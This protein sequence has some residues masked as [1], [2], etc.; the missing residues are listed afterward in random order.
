MEKTFKTWNLTLIR[1]FCTREYDIQGSKVFVRLLSIINVY[2]QEKQT[3]S[4]LYSKQ[5]FL[6]SG[7]NFEKDHKPFNGYFEVDLGGHAPALTIIW[8]APPSSMCV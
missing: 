3:F 4:Q 2:L 8:Q 5:K 6:R 7:Q 1:V